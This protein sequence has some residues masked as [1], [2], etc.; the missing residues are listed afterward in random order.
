MPSQLVLPLATEPQLGRA[1]FIV[2]PGNAQAV[3]FI[4]AWP[5]W[6]VAAAALYGPAGSG[7]THLAAA[8]AAVSGAVRVAAGDL[9]AFPALAGPAVV[10]DVD[11][12]PPGPERDAAL[13]RLIEGA[14]PAHPVLLT[15]REQAADWPTQLPDLASRFGALLSLPLWA[16]DDSLLAALARKLL[17]DRQVTVPPGVV[18]RIVHSLERTPQSIRD[19]IAR[20]DARALSE[21]RPINLALVRELLAEEDR[22]LS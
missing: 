20:A 18:E 19:F 11:C 6:P 12:C 3:A 17:A 13:F 16:P 8:W 5:H 7:K 4:D 22:G 10:E 1:D 14:T 9:A 15:G 21:A 2:A